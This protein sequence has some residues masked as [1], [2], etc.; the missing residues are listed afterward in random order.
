[1]VQEP[2]HAADLIRQKLTGIY[3]GEPN[4]SLELKE[5]EAS[6]HRSKHQEYM[7]SLTTS[8]KSLA[9][10]QTA[11]HAYYQGLPDK[12]KHEV[13]NEFYRE[14]DAKRSPARTEN[15]LTKT[16]PTVM[17]PD[18]T[19]KQPSPEPAAENV[20]ELRKLL[21]RRAPKRQAKQHLHSLGFGLMCGFIAM[22]IFMFGFFNERFV[23][24][25][26]TPSKDVSNAP[27]V[28]DDATS[29]A[30]KDPILTIPKINVQIPVVY[31]EPS[32][33]EDAVQKAL[34]SG[35]LHYATTPNPGEKGNGVIFGHSSN[36]IFN[37]GKYK[38]AFVLLKKMENG[39]TFTLQ[40]DGKRYVYK[41]YDKKIVSPSELSV[42]ETQGGRAATMT[43][44]TC[45]PPGT[46][47]SRLVVFG[48]Q[49]T[50]DPAKNVASTAKQDKGTPV[51][52]PSNAPTLWS[53]LW[54]WLAR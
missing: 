23:A 36:N 25:F 34:E 24:P 6:K 19:P 27:I 49:I 53:R 5:A 12:E 29:P 22:I 50:P 16:G 44:I 7:H 11:W 52:L 4:A 17:P 13:W 46:S 14:Y 20:H 47:I 54:H 39:D 48:E 33:D 26:I 8:G 1:M 15:P 3:G 30:G 42:L 45:E 32:I 28:I 37:K 9:E 38:F 51:I 18:M 35:V 43:L 2:E 31:T 40:K 41:V 10:I 21:Q